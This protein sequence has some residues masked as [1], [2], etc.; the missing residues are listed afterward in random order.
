MIEVVQNQES[1]FFSSSWSVFQ[2]GLETGS[3]E[4]SFQWGTGARYCS[5]THTSLWTSPV[6]TNWIQPFRVKEK[7]L[8]F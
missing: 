2:L 4:S 5:C 8:H 6:I 3:R 1:A 7:T